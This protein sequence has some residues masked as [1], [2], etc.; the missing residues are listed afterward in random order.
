MQ[1]SP[2]LMSIY[3]KMHQRGYARRTIDTYLYWIKY[4]IN[5]NKQQHPSQLHNYEVS[6]FLTFLSNE[7]QVTVNTQKTALNALVYLYKHILDLP[8]SK[9]IGFQRSQ[10]P[11]K[12]PV[13]LTMDEI[14]LYL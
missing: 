7:Q 12:L 2:F 1:N 8:L 6:D 11:Q 3:R 10:S 5:F 13:V 9:E 4:F 14:R